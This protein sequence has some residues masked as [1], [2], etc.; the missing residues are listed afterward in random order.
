MLFRSETI[1]SG[2]TEEIV[3][4]FGVVPS[5]MNFLAKPVTPKSLSLKVR[6]MLD[7]D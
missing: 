6:E 2:Y 4:R 7:Q 1:S 5:D 3:S